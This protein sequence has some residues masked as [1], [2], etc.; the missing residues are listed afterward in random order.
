MSTLVKQASWREV[1][2]LFHGHGGEMQATQ[3]VIGWMDRYGV[4]V[5][6]LKAATVTLEAWTAE[7]LAEVMDVMSRAEPRLTV[8]MVNGTNNATLAPR[9]D[10]LPAAMVRFGDKYGIIDGKHRVNRWKLGGG[11]WAVL[12]IHA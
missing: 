1:A 12:V 5:G 11:P 2:D 9:L 6:D 3:N 10:G 4:K 8:D 7:E